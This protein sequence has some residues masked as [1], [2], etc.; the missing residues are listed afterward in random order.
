MS[1]VNISAIL[2]TQ[3]ARNFTARAIV[4]VPH[5]FLKWAGGKRQLLAQLHPFLP[6]TFHRYIE[7]FIGGGA[8]FFYLLPEQAILMDNNPE[9]INC[10]Q[11]I[12]TAVEPLINHLCQH[13]NESAY[14][15]SIR[16]LDRAPNYH[17]LSPVERASRTIYLN[18]CC[19]NGLY[20]VNSHG[21]FNVPFGRYN[22]PQFCDA[23]NLR[24]VHQVLQHT[25]IR[26]ASFQ[27]CLN[28]AQK[29]DFLYFDP[30]YVPLS[31]SS[32]FTSYTADNFDLAAQQEL[33]EVFRALDQRGCL[34][35]LSNSFNETVLDLY[36]KYSC[37]TV[38]ATRIVNSKASG[39]GKIKEILITNYNIKP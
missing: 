14:F 23:V 30:P 11:V 5:P 19:Y 35:L 18:R 8:L 12:Q 4:D 28:I 15:Y 2:T 24:A 34:L 16:A 36:R 1:S 29:D 21:Y 7:P 31:K 33:Y 3:R 39:R 38:E 26:L 25:D 32:S 13:R 9:L 27:E 6:R 17:T 20:R 10:Y 37:Y 22:N